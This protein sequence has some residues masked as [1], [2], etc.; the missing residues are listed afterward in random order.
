MFSRAFF[1]TLNCLDRETGEIM[2]EQ[3]PEI[4]VGDTVQIVSHDGF[5][6]EQGV[7]DVILPAR[8]DEWGDAYFV[9]F[10]MKRYGRQVVPF[11]RNEVRRIEKERS[12]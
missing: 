7:I 5:N 11:K 4:Q 3:Q 1:A 8:N 2:S 12:S 9:D 6:G 10:G